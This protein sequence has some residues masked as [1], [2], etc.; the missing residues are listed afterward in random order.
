MKFFSAGAIHHD[1]GWMVLGEQRE[2]LAFLSIAM[3]RAG[4]LRQQTQR[5][6]K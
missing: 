6:G 1:S 2:G 5:S 3:T 4:R